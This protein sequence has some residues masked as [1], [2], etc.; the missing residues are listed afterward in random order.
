MLFQEQNDDSNQL[1]NLF[2]EGLLNLSKT[3]WATYLTKSNLP[4]SDINTVGLIISPA[5]VARYA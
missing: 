1:V 4:I 3:F 2:F 5:R